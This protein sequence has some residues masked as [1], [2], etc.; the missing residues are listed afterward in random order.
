VAREAGGWH[1]AQRPTHAP[2]RLTPGQ[3]RLY[4][5]SGSA[6][7]CNDCQH[8]VAQTTGFPETLQELGRS[9]TLR[10]AAQAFA[11]AKDA[12]V[13]YGSDCMGLSETA[14]LAQAC[15]NLLLTS[16]HLGRANN[17]LL[18]VWPR[19]NDQGAW[20]LGWR[21]A[22]NLMESLDQ[23]EALYIAAADPVSDDPAYQS[24][25]GGQKFVVVQDLYLSQTA[26]LADVVLPLNHGP[27]ARAA[28]PPANGAFSVFTRR[29]R[30]RH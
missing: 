28:T 22:D 21:P 24:A 25:F 30:Q 19:A 2:D 20:E 10:Q 26:R 6:H 7:R 17:G 15:S 12:I 11:D 18:A 1:G 9:T 27:S 14:A 5:F 29:F 16:D 13:I 4:P 3:V 8:P 23:A